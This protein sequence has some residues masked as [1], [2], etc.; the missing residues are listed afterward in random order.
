MRLS[1]G[2]MLT[3]GSQLGTVVNQKLCRAMLHLSESFMVPILDRRRT[4]SIIKFRKLN[5]ECYSLGE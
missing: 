3:V 4:S 2:H 5:S 1:R